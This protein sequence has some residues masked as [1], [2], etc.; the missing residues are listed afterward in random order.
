MTST[1]STPTPPGAAI[2]ALMLTAS[3]SDRC[4]LERHPGNI[5]A[6]SLRVRPPRTLFR[7]FTR[8]VPSMLVVE[9]EPTATSWIV[10]RKSR[11]SF[12]RIT[13]ACRSLPGF[14]R[15]SVHEC[16]LSGVDVSGC[17]AH[18]LCNTR[19]ISERYV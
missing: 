3:L 4:H 19:F 18:H 14:D 11:S 15:C 1:C 6:R 10:C 12:Y 8:M 9:R 7:T 17:A 13:I 5:C 16:A 2:V